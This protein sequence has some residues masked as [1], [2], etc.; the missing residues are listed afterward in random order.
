MII[1]TLL[2]RRAGRALACLVA[3]M[4]C[5][6]AAFWGA[7]PEWALLGFAFVMA[8]IHLGADVR[9]PNCGQRIAWVGLIDRTPTSSMKD[10]ACDF[11]VHCDLNLGAEI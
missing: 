1:R 8:G 3:G 11:C 10:P 9:C 2:R 4:L 6:M 7:M 5:G